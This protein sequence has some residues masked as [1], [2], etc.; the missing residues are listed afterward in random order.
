MPVWRANA[1][2]YRIHA[3]RYYFERHAYGVVRYGRTIPL[4]KLL[5][6]QKKSPRPGHMRYL[7]GAAG[8]GLAARKYYHQLYYMPLNVVSPMT[9][10]DDTHELN[11]SANVPLIPALSG[12]WKRA[13]TYDVC[14][15]AHF[16]TVPYAIC[17]TLPPF[18]SALLPRKVA[19]IRPRFWPPGAAI[20]ENYI[21]FALYNARPVS[22]PPLFNSQVHQVPTH[23]RYIIS[24]PMHPRGIVITST[25]FLSSGRST[26]SQAEV[27]EKHFTG[28]IDTTTS[29]IVAGIAT[30]PRKYLSGPAP[31]ALSSTLHD[32]RDVW[33]QH[34]VAT[35]AGLDDENDHDGSGDEDNHDG[36]G[37]G[38]GSCDES[39]GW[40][41]DGDDNM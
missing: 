17:L 10:M 27:P 6:S 3:Q 5:S 32:G 13:N 16:P 30:T 28:H 35:V 11:A 40:E 19:K 14:V 38:D 9:E 15:G 22:R 7:M 2:K 23:Y 20:S 37:A 29:P 25:V 26:S 18:N 8:A 24:H 1:L 36:A 4:N 12:N 41:G 21:Q 34:A 33:P 31:R 39:G